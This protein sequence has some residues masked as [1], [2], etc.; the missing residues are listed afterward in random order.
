MQIK[1]IRYFLFSH[2]KSFWRPKILNVDE[3]TGKSVLLYT[4]EGIKMG[5][6]FLSQFQ[7]YF[8]KFKCAY[9]LFQSQLVGIHPAVMLPKVIKEMHT[10]VFYCTIV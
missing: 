4:S 9:I 10:I 7:N 8:Q 5:L 3:D 6:A 1:S 2:W